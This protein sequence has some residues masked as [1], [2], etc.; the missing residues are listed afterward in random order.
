MA[1]CNMKLAWYSYS[2]WLVRMFTYGMCIH[3][4]YCVQRRSA[5]SQQSLSY[6]LVFL[7]ASV[8]WSKEDVSHLTSK[9]CMVEHGIACTKD[10]Y[11]QG[12]HAGRVEECHTNV[13]VSNKESKKNCMNTLTVLSYGPVVVTFICEQKM[14]AVSPALFRCRCA[15]LV[16]W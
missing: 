8:G 6:K 15:S 3:L 7:K 9:L 4:L 16:Y 5:V 13:V 12:L 11:W 1:W 2:S 14:Y 10:L